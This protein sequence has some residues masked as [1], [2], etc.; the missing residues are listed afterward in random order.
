MK[1]ITLTKYPFQ[2]G[3]QCHKALW[4]NYNNPE[5]KTP[6]NE[7]Q[8]MI[9]D[10]GTEVGIIA[11]QLYSGGRDLSE[12]D[13]VY[14]RELMEKT[15]AALKT[16]EQIFYEA[17][18]ETLDRRMNCKVDIFVRSER[19]TRL[20]EV[21]SSTSIKTP[22]H[23]LDLAFQYYVLKNSSYTGPPLQV[24]L[25]YLNKEYVRGV[26]LDVDELFVMEDVTRR[27]IDAQVLI[28][29]YLVQFESV[30]KS[31]QCPNNRVSEAC[32]KPY[33]CAFYNHCWKD[34][35]PITVF[36]L[37]RLR[38][39]KATQLI[40]EGIVELTQIPSDM[41][42][43]VEQWVQVEATKKGSPSINH[44]EITKFL[45]TLN[46]DQPTFWMDFETY[47]SPIPEYQG[48][49]PYQQICFQ[50]CVLL[51]INGQID[52]RE[53]LAERGKDPRRAFIESLLED[54]E[55]EGKIIVYNQAFEIARL[56][57]LAREFPELEGDIQNRIERIRDLL[58]PFAKKYY[59]HPLMKGSASIKAVLPVLVNSEELSYNN[60]SIK[61]GA[62]A[63]SLYEKFQQLELEKQIETRRALLEY[64][65][66]DCLGMIKVAEALQNLVN[67]KPK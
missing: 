34:L 14:G 49:H 57:E 9:M 64:C 37:S 47:M 58:I 40:E 59:Y 46:L 20:I 22:D 67:H 39:S 29:N 60:L 2:K 33:P 13:T 51:S 17:S 50:Y 31:Q 43:S 62:M 26:E 23:I 53:F 5:L 16:D 6:P 44:G 45:G 35:P 36:N 65:H 32:F 10:K 55:G 4:L 28:K 21:K 3:T 52:R 27:I 15:Q 8:R 41:K 38:K 30:L 11:R 42:L 61:N 18:F 12:N 54:T 66:L 7:E 25:V 63:M 1:K 48:T 56:R 19:N 24:Y